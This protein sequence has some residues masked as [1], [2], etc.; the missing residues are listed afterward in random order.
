MEYTLG[1]ALLRSGRSSEALPHLRRG[2]DGGTKAKVAGYD[3]AVALQS[4]GDLQAAAQVIARIQPAPG[5]DAEVWLQI[6]RLAAAVKAPELA[7]RFFKQGAA[8]SPNDSGARL[9]YGLSLLV[10]N[11]TAEA[12]REFDAAVRLDPRDPDALAHLAYSELATGRKEDARRHAEAAL[13][14]APG[15]ALASAVRFK[16]DGK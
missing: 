6:G 1:Q 12:L 10:L 15:H 4:A 9:Q 7:E 14:I 3:L 2:F 8:L 16:L 13:A 5:D 11:R